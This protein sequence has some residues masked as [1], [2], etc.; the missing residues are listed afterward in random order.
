MHISGCP[1]TVTIETRGAAR[2]VR[3]SC[4]RMGTPS[5][6]AARRGRE[7]DLVDAGGTAWGAS[8]KRSADGKASVRR[9]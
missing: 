7:L 2:S 1:D 6:T 5:A 4:A 8:D 9:V 3:R